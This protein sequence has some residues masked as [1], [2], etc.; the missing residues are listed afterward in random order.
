MPRGRM[1]PEETPI[2]EER[3]ASSLHRCV[4]ALA[5]GLRPG[6]SNATELISAK[7]AEQSRLRTPESR[8]GGSASVGFRDPAGG[9]L[10]LSSAIPAGLP[11]RDRAAKED[12]SRQETG[13]R[14]RA[15][16]ADIVCAA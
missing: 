12:Q 9:K 3:P 8:I 13:A 7:V 15:M 4:C 14:S 16:I 6:L 5:G 10:R 2:R 1:G 11:F